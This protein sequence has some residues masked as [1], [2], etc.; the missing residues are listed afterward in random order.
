MG[1]GWLVASK[2]LLNDTLPETNIFAPENGWFEYDRFPLGPGL[3][4]G[5]IS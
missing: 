4:S 3:V 5:D 2:W 1:S